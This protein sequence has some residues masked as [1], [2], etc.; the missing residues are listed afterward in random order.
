[1]KEE[2]DKE[3]IERFRKLL[4]KAVK[5][6]RYAEKKAEAEARTCSTSERYMF[7]LLNR[8]EQISKRGTLV[9][10]GKSLVGE[11]LVLFFRKGVY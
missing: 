10:D 11:E 4:Q 7:R 5:Q 1:M 9:I 3:K 6:M 2:T 8:L